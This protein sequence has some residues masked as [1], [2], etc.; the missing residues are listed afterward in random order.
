MR[1]D[2][3]VL[4]DDGR[5]SDEL[6]AVPVTRSNRTPR[7][8][9]AKQRDVCGMHAV[10]HGE[11]AS[12]IAIVGGIAECRTGAEPSPIECYNQRVR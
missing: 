8:V 12:S 6:S 1:L 3:L 9:L 10:A 7:R 5:I 2:R 11:H 4:R